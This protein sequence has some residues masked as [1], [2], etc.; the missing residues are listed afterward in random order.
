M[1]PSFA[2]V[3]ESSVGDTALCE[4]WLSSERT[5]P[6]PV[7]LLSPST[8]EAAWGQQLLAG[9]TG[10]TADPR[11]PRDPTRGTTSAQLQ[12]AAD[13]AALGLVTHQAAGCEPPWPFHHLYGSGLFI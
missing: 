13:A 9:D 10:G 6:R 1:G 2:F 3:T 8:R 7:L 12:L 5:V 4:P 11:D